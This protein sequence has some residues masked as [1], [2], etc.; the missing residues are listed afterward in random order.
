MAR[1]SDGHTPLHIA[2]DAGREKVVRE[3][4]TQYK[5]PVN[6]VSSVGRTPLHLAAVRVITV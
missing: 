5:C 6:C 3:F 2:A 4:V 1:D